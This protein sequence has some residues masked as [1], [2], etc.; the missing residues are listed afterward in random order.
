MGIVIFNNIPSTTV[1]VVVEHRPHYQT[2]AK[3]YEIIHVAG[4]NGD[5]IIDKGSYQ[6]ANRAYDI[7]FGSYEK[8]HSEMALAVSEWLHSASGYARLE[9]TYE[10]DYYRMACYQEEMQLENIL[11]HFGRATI[12]FNCK[13]QRFMKSGDRVITFTKSGESIINPTSFEALPII[14]IYGTGECILGVNG[15]RIQ[16]T[17]VGNSITLNS[18]LQ[19]AYLAGSV[20]QPKND[21]VKLLSG[22]YQSFQKGANEITWSGSGVTRVEV[23][24]KWW[25]L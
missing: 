15:T 3:D 20:N 1:H 22:G 8:K 16:I 25:T 9:D 12:N 7:A 5:V 17:D 4:R 18:E 14:T 21:K 10:P 19:E 11:N 2:P 6:N 13:P 23:V 24:P